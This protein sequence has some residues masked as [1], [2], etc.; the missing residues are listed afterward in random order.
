MEGLAKLAVIG[1]IAL[2]FFGG[3]A[4]GFSGASMLTYAQRCL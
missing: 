2:V 4:L 3:V 1:F